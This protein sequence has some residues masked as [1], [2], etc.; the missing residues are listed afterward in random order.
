MKSARKVVTVMPAMGESKG[1]ARL[2][3]NSIRHVRTEAIQEYVLEDQESLRC[4]LL[5]PRP[6]DYYRL[7]LR[8]LWAMSCVRTT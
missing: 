3:G 6:D 4:F 2:V 8:F 1:M 5:F 7:W